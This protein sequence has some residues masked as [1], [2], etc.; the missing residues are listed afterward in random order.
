MRLP[1]RVKRKV[2]S[3]LVRPAMIYELEM[4]GVAM[5]QVEEMKI[6]EIK[7]LRFATGVTKKDKF[8]NKYNRGTVKIE[9]LGIKMREERLRWY[10]HVMARD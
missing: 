8:R 1:A 9:R 7:M 5:K 4:V 3:S 2:Y 6:T 10:G